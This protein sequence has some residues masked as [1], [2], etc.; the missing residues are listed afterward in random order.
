M[1]SL[2]F[3]TLMI[4][5]RGAVSL[6]SDKIESFAVRRGFRKSQEGKMEIMRLFLDETS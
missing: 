2:T 1:S 6:T 5:S 4:M 3:V